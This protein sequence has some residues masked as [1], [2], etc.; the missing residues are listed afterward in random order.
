MMS[1]EAIKK[2]TLDIM[3]AS[4][5]LADGYTLVSADKIFP[6]LKQLNDQLNVEDWAL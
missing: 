6:A 3:L 5:A 1:K 2:H 4:C